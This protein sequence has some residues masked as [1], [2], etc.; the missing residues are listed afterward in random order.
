M[1]ISV[2]YHMMARSELIIQRSVF[3]VQCSMFRQFN[4]LAES[5][6]PFRV[7]HYKW[8]L[9]A[10]A[11]SLKNLS[12]PDKNYNY[13][14]C[15]QKYD[16]Q[17]QATTFSLINAWWLAEASM[18]AFATLGVR[19]VPTKKSGAYMSYVSTFCRG[20]TQT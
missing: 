7:H 13:F 17:F 1:M 18:L 11:I 4:Y 19:Q 8:W 20:V 5:V 12:P 15:I 2:F 9:N 16:F 10:R 14:Q 3:D 6:E